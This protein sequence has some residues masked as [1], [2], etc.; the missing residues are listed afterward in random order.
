MAGFF[1]KPEEFVDIVK[2]IHA[3]VYSDGGAESEEHKAAVRAALLRE[4]RDIQAATMAAEQQID[5]ILRGELTEPGRVN[6]PIQV[7]VPRFHY[8]DGAHG[9]AHHGG[10]GGG[11]RHREHG[12]WSRLR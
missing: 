5:K 11:G 9:G 3:E 12:A 7:D 1:E 6:D 10:G 2:R 4:A 8:M